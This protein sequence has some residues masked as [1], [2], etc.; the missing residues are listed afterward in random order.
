[1]TNEVYNYEDKIIGNN[2]ITSAPSSSSQDESISL[3]RIDYKLKRKIIIKLHIV[4][5]LI[6]IW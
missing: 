3:S 5:K 1:M 2:P 6:F 4:I